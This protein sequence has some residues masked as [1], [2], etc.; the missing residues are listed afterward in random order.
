MLLLACYAAAQATVTVV[1]TGGNSRTFAV[2]ATGEIYFGTDY[3]AV[4]PS[5]NSSELEIIQ[6]DDIEKVLFDGSVNIVDVEGTTLTLAPNP[7]GAS[8]ALH[9]M[10]TGPQLVTVYSMSGTAVLQGRYSD[11][12]AIGIGSLPQGIYMVRAAGSIVKLI[13][14]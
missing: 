8:F 4:M 1:G 10:G 9:G 2:D 11:G 12:E 7:A 14:R 6:M 5:A 3:M 13:K